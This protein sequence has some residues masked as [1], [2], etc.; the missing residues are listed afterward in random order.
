MKNSI[1]LSGVKDPSNT[2][3]LA[4]P[5]ENDSRTTGIASLGSLREDQVM[6]RT[7]IYLNFAVT[8]IAQQPLEVLALR[9]RVAARHPDVPVM[10]KE[11]AAALTRLPGGG[12]ALRFRAGF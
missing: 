3:V 1:V 9:V 5:Y 8:A 4:T 11:L 7:A 12:A 2:D 6:S 10:P